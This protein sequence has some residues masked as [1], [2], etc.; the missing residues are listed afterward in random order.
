ML[1]VEPAGPVIPVYPKGPVSPIGPD[2]PEK[3]KEFNVVSLS[4][5]FKCL[6]P[7]DTRYQDE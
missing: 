3:K 4:V 1:P 7:M 6:A 5:S 2:A